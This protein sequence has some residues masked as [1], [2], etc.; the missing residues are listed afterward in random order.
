MSKKY[1]IAETTKVQRQKIAWDA[2]GIST[3]DAAMP[4]EQTMRHVQEY[5]DGR[6]EISMILEE[7]IVQYR[8]A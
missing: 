5:V 1:T 8:K 3:L 2:L 4:S 7:T 6:K